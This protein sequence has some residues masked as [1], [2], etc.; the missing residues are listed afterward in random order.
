MLSSNHT[1]T[2][3]YSFFQKSVMIP[4]P[5]AFLLFSYHLTVSAILT[6][7][8]F[9]KQPELVLVSVFYLLTMSLPGMLLPQIS[10]WLNSITSFMT[11]FKYQIYVGDTAKRFFCAWGA[12]T[13]QVFKIFYH[14]MNVGQ[15]SQKYESAPKLPVSCFYLPSSS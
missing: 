3:F 15:K 14:L 4:A 5:V 9:S 2:L 11:L 6:S 8:L 7:L 13:N 10:T 1:F 12:T